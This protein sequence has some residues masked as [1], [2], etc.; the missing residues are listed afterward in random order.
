MTLSEY[1]KVVAELSKEVNREDPTDFSGT[2]IDSK[3]VWDLMA[4]EVVE[5]YRPLDPEM[6]S[7]IWLATI[8]KLVVENFVLNSKLLNK[9]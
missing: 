4:S 1:V 2:N 6:N 5:R 8:T 3:R 9:R 7:P